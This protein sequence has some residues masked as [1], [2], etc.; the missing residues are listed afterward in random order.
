[1]FK[2]LWAKVHSSS[3]AEA[4]D[5]AGFFASATSQLRM[6]AKAGDKKTKDKLEELTDWLESVREETIGS[7]RRQVKPISASREM[8]SLA[9]EQLC[10]HLRGEVEQSN[11]LRDIDWRKITMRGIVKVV[12]PLVK[13]ESKRLVLSR[14]QPLGRSLGLEGAFAGDR[15]GDRGGNRPCVPRGGG[16]GLYANMAWTK[17]GSRPISCYNCGQLGHYS[18][19][20]PLNR[21]PASAA[22]VE[23]QKKQGGGAP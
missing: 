11:F 9:E 5:L 21:G 4:N 12:S 17:D 3:L 23:G 14:G 16:K 18:N 15:R 10:L 7:F 19:E 2:R 1:M 6:E 20:C 22:V 13:E 8:V